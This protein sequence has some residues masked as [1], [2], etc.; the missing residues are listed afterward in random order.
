MSNVDLFD[1]PVK[2]KKVRKGVVAHQ[3]RNGVIN[4]NGQKY[5]MYTMTAAIAKYRRD[6]PKH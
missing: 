1:T 5:L 4:I 2:S 3:Y 6:Y